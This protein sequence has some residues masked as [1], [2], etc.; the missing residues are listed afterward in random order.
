VVISLERSAN[1]LHM[2]QLIPLPP[3]YLASLQSRMVLPFSYRHTQVVL[4]KRWLNWMLLLFPFFNLPIIDTPTLFPSASIP[5]SFICFPFLFVHDVLLLFLF[6]YL[7]FLALFLFPSPP[8][9]FPCNGWWRGDMGMLL[10]MHQSMIFSS[11]SASFVFLLFVL[12]TA[13][14]LGQLVTI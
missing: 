13:L 8:L 4:E 2:V 5:Q 7:F 12:V 10:V 14:V 3:H 9:F 1:D 11:P 6:P